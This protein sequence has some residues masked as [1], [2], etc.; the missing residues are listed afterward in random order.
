MRPTVWCGSRAAKPVYTGR[1]V[2]QSP[3]ALAGKN[4]LA[5]AAIGD[6]EKFFA[7]LE[8]AGIRVAARKAFGD[9][10]FF[11]DDEI[12]ELLDEAELYGLT[13]VTTAKD[14]VRLEGGHGRARE[15]AEKAEVLEV[16][17]AFDQPDAAS[18]IVDAAI[19]ACK[20]RLIGRG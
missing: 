7:T 2:P 1:L 5:F 17:L 3:E 11:T 16:R 14:A 13:P 18:A 6:P 19:A 15:L 12:D 10:H 8:A 20:R 4:C 9:H